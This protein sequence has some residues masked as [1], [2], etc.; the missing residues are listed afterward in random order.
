MRFRGFSLMHSLLESHQEDLKIVR[1]VRLYFRQSLV[2][3]AFDEPNPRLILQILSP[4]KNWPLINRNK[5]E[6][7]NIEEPVKRIAEAAY[8][9]CPDISSLAQEVVTLFIHIRV[10]QQR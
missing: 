1:L 2:L 9:E 6:D 7:S 5:V 3:T 4:L 8:P 10:V